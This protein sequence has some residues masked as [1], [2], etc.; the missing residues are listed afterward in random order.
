LRL[1]NRKNAFSI[2][3]DTFVVPSDC[4]AI[5][6]TIKSGEVVAVVAVAAVAAEQGE[7]ENIGIATTTRGR[8]RRPPIHSR[9]NYLGSTND[10]S[11]LMPI[12]NSRG[13][14]TSNPPTRHDISTGLLSFPRFPLAPA[15]A[16][17]LLLPLVSNR[18]NTARPPRRT[19]YR[20]RGRP[21]T[22]IRALLR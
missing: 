14:P 17:L 3:K 4:K 20:S 5:V 1:R 7:R 13:R 2:P 15:L 8:L 11:V 9:R 22:A 19:P 10:K 12:K 6:Q 16:I 21:G 18:C